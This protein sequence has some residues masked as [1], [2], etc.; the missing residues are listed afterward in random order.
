MIH[1]L[2][3]HMRK[4][5]LFCSILKSL[6]EDQVIKVFTYLLKRIIIKFHTSMN[7]KIVIVMWFSKAVTFQASYIE[8]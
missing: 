5:T 2:V 7:F 4:A 8:I 3:S 6:L 1:F